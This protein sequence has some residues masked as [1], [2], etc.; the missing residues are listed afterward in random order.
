[1]KIISIVSFNGLL[2]IKRTDSTEYREP[3]TYKL[4]NPNG[5]A[6]ERS[7]GSLDYYINGKRHREDGP[8]KVR[9]NGR[10]EWWTDGFLVK[11]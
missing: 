9:P 2:K 7:N 4:H 8:A 10:I 11:T 3:R 5:P 6:I 1:M